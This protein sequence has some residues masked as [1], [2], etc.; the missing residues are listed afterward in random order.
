MGGNYHKH[1]GAELGHFAIHLAPVIGVVL[2][3]EERPIILVHFVPVIVV[4]IARQAHGPRAEEH[5][6]LVVISCRHSFQHRI[7]LFT[8]KRGPHNTTRKLNG[9][10]LQ[11][12]LPADYGLMGPPRKILRRRRRSS[13]GGER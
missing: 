8:K 12:R 9:N 4:A 13:E 11:R 2:M 3:M 1:E 7:L 6:R 5:G 10:L